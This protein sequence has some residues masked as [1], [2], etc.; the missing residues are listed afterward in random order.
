M[1]IAYTA[2]IVLFI[3]IGLIHSALGEFLIFRRLRKGGIVPT[4][5]ALPLRSRHT[6]ILWASWHIASI[7]GWGMA[8]IL[9]RLSMETAEH[10]TFIVR[11]IAASA[12]LSGALVLL[13][14]GGR[15]PGWLG[16]SVAGV[17]LLI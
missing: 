6:R 14:T 4:E 10:T 7:F 15:H 1:S 8:A 11:A 16:L 12:L 3:L 9:W 5:A 13:A 2:A 17:L